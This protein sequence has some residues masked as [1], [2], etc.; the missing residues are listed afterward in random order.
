MYNVFFFSFFD[1]HISKA[2]QKHANSFSLPPPLLN[3][4]AQYFTPVTD[5]ASRFTIKNPSEYSVIQRA[6]SI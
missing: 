4:Y 2:I 6:S 3:Y 1:Q 5:S